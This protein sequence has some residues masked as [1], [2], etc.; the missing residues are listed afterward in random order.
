MDA[1]IHELEYPQDWAAKWFDE[2]NVRKWFQPYFEY[3][4]TFMKYFELIIQ[5]LRT[6]GHFDT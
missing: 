2:V 1:L 5:F 6:N 3:S 4:P